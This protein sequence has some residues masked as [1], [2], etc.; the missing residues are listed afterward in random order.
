[1]FDLQQIYHSGLR[2]ADVDRAMA[3]LGPALGVTWARVQYSD[4]R[5]VWTPERGL[6]QVELTFVYS[7]EGPQHVELLQGGSVWDAGDAP[8]LHHLGVWSDDVGADVE[9]FLAAGWTVA[10]AATAPE[11]GFG[12]FAYVAP[13]SGL[14]IELV[15][16][17]AK[18][19]FDTWFAGGSLGSDRD[20]TP[21][22]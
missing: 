20:V 4:N 17:A 14:I 5:T 1:M 9:R 8:G 21:T 12:S 15:A 22:D 16:S 6:E 11:D 18:P 19:R 10:A 7:C 2:V 3:E 13:P